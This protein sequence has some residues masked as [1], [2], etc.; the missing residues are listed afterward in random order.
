MAIGGQPDETGRTFKI[1]T[2]ASCE[3]DDL[4]RM[5]IYDRAGYWQIKTEKAETEAE[6]LKKEVSF[7]QNGGCSACTNSGEDDNCSFNGI[8]C[9]DKRN[10]FELQE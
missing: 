3:H 10:G 4:E 5:K 9:E 8:C 1:P 7:W 2:L 6:Q